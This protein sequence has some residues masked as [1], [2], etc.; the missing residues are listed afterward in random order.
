MRDF[1]PA[2][3]LQHILAGRYRTQLLKNQSQDKVDPK[4]EYQHTVN[5][6]DGVAAGREVP[7]EDAIQEKAEEQKFQGHKQHQ[8]P[9]NDVRGNFGLEIAGPSDG[10]P[11]MLK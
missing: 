3:A 11:L 6:I 1:F 7:A 9:K 10:F 4:V 8:K 5:E 2:D